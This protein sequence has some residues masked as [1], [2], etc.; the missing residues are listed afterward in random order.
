MFNVKKPEYADCN[1]HL[2]NKPYK[3]YCSF[4]HSVKWSDFYNNPSK[5]IDIA[6]AIR[7]NIGDYKLTKTIK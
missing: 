6:V 2:G 7:Q 4:I 5:F 1:N 3:G